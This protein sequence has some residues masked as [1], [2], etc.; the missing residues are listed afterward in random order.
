MVDEVMVNH[1]SYLKARITRAFLFS[2]LIEKIELIKMISSGVVWRPHHLSS[3]KKLFFYN[4]DYDWFLLFLL[5]V[6]QQ[7]P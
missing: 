3:K 6:K 7:K 4:D 5:M 1:Q 2:E